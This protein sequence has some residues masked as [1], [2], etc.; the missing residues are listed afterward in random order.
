MRASG[1]RTPPAT[2][3]TQRRLHLP[4]LATVHDFGVVA[5]PA[6][7]RRVLPCLRHGLAADADL[8]IAPAPIVAGDPF[9]AHQARRRTRAYPA[10]SAPAS[11]GSASRARGCSTS[12]TLP[13]SARRPRSRRDRTY[14]GLRSSKRCGSDCR[15]FPG[16]FSGGCPAA[17]IPAFPR[18]AP[19][20][21]SG[22]LE[23]DNFRSSPHQV[24]GRA[25]PDQASTCDDHAS[26]GAWRLRESCGH[27]QFV[28]PPYLGPRQ[29]VPF[30]AW[31]SGTSLPSRRRSARR[32]RAHMWRK[33]GVTRY[34]VRSGCQS[35]LNTAAG[36]ETLLTTGVGER[37][38]HEVEEYCPHTSMVRFWCEMDDPTARS[39]QS[40]RG[41]NT[42]R[43]DAGPGTRPRSSQARSRSRTRS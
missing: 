4:G 30:R 37:T 29:A 7:Q 22:A 23:D 21:S 8:Q 13:A 27:W 43:A 35:I 24:P 12:R 20:P 26:K 18:E 15:T 6:H 2:R 32:G 33:K 38:R 41:L 42:G 3:G 31:R 10:P 28:S 39:L 40:L 17:T 1:K 25:E 16:R 34:I 5:A 36:D 9:F 14:S 19:A 11:P